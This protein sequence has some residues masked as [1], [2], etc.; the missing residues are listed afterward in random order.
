MTAINPWGCVMNNNLLLLGGRVLL[1]ILFLVSGA[2]KFGA[3]GSM[4][5]GMLGQMGLPAPLLLTYLIGLA[6]V[7][8]GIALILGIQTRLVG[9]LLAAWC[10]L[11]GLVVH[12]GMPADL[13]KNLALAG[14]LLVLAATSPGSLVLHTNWLKRDRPAAMA[15]SSATLNG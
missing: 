11:T 5:A 9:I 15:P 2:G 12:V 3:I 13:M 1:S 4:L 14:G 7:V 6:E 8:G 10:V